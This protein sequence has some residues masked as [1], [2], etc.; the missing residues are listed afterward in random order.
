MFTIVPKDSS[1]FTSAVLV[2]P[3]YV[4]C[5]EAEQHESNYSTTSLMLTEMHKHPCIGAFCSSQKD[6][7]QVLLVW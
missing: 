2:L 6:C 3:A 7:H 1:H 5:L 4:T